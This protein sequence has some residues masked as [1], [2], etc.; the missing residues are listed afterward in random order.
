M[1][2]KAEMD[3][4]EPVVVRNNIGRCPFSI[5]EESTRLSTSS[6]FSKKHNEKEPPRVKTLLPLA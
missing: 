4:V 2:S 3:T 5:K 6:S 1:P